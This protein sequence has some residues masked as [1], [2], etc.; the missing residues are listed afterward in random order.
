MYIYIILYIYVNVI[1][2]VIH[3]ELGFSIPYKSWPN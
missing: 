1:H 3:L 2:F